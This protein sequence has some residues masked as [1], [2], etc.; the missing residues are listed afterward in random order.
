MTLDFPLDPTGYTAG[1]GWR[2]LRRKT[3]MQRGWDVFDFQTRL[4]ALGNS[5]A[6]DGWFGDQTDRAT[7]RFQEAH[8][9]IRDGIA[10]AVTQVASGKSVALLN[11]PLSD[12]VRGQMQREC[13]MLC[14]IYTPVYDNGSQ[15]RGAVQMNSK[16]H[17]DNGEA[18]DVR[19]CV[20]V[21]VATIKQQHSRFVGW[22]TEDMRAWAAAQGYWNN[23]VYAERYA[24][25]E[26]VPDSF[27]EYIEAVTAFV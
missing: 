13:S 7:V 18:F 2:P 6:C 1:H 25:S 9:L 15:D 17:P 11:G 23:H 27:M 8:N 22:G 10:G 14:G 26:P 5:L 21:L 12:R 24:R 4:V 19:N 16:Y 3:P 20:A